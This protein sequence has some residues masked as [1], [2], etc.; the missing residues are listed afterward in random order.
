MFLWV[1]CINLLVWCLNITCSNNCQCVFI[2]VNSFRV[3]FCWSFCESFILIQHQEHF[4]SL[5]WF[6]EDMEVP[7]ELGVGVI[8]EGASSFNEI[9]IKS[10][11]TKS[12]SSSIISLLTLSRFYWAYCILDQ[13]F[14]K[15]G[16][17]DLSS[18]VCRNATQYAN[19]HA[20]IYQSDLQNFLKLET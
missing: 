14:T 10:P 12:S 3:W 20:I 6:L 19:M 13:Q 5:P 11:Q 8:E 17:W 15:L 9:F 4:I 16:I 7:D 18:S 1:M 2:F